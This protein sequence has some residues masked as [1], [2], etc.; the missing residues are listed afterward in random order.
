MNFQSINPYTSEVISKH[1]LHSETE[2][3]YILLNAEK[4][5]QHWYKTK[6]SHR[7]QCLLKCSEQLLF[8]KS[9]LAILIT[10]EMGKLL[11]ESEAEIEKCALL[12]RYYAEHL[13][14]FLTPRKMYP[15]TTYYHEI[16]LDALGVIFGI[17]PWNFP[18][19]QVFRFAVP[20][21]AAGNVVVVKHAH[22]VCGCGKAIENIFLQAGFEQGIFQ[23]L[24]IKTE[25]IEKVIAHPAVRAVSLTGSEQAGKSVAALAGKYLKKTVLE[26]GSN[27]VFVVLKDADLLSAADEAAKSRLINNGQSCVAAKRFIVEESIYDEFVTYFENN[28]SKITMGDPM[29]TTT[30]LGPLARLDLCQQLLKQVETSI[31]LGAVAKKFDTNNHLGGAFMNPT[32]L[33]QV[34]KPSPAYSEELFGPVASVFKVKNGDEALNLANDSVYGLAASVWTSDEKN[35]ILF[36]EQ[37]QV[38]AIFFNA[39]VQSHPAM[40]FGGVKNA[41]Y[42][43]E[44]GEYGL[45]EFVNIKTIKYN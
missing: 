31:S 32:I 34:P 4:T 41:G 15:D 33:Y 17:M 5:Q 44:L 20:A 40:P 14:Q 26:L 9:E 13:E 38:G 35:Q 21:I 25:D 45:Q 19:W 16:R 36:S 6:V 11:R 7:I 8:Y 39:M 29:K 27:D 30:S 37:L 23:N 24:F 22:N 28:V 43:R 3:L 10:Q 18:F 42:G 12:C 2:L 1:D